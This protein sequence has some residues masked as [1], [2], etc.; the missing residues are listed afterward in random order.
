M[1]INGD[2]FIKRMDSFVKATDEHVKTTS[3]LLKRMEKFLELEDQ[4]AEEA[5][6]LKEKRAYVKAKDPLED[7]SSGIG[8]SNILLQDILNEMKKKRGSGFGDTGGLNLKKLG[9][10]AAA[11][12]A[13]LGSESLMNKIIQEA[14]KPLTKRI[15]EYGIKAVERQALKTGSE[16]VVKKGSEIVTEDLIKKG[17]E[18]IVQEGTETAAKKGSEELANKVAKTG[19]KKVLKTAAKSAAKIAKFI[20]GIGFVVATPFAIDRLMKGDYAGAALEMGSAIPGPIG[21]GIAGASAARDIWFKSDEQKQAEEG[22]GWFDPLYDK[23]KNKAIKSFKNEFI[24]EPKNSSIY[25]RVKKYDNIIESEAKQNSLSPNMIRALIAQES[26]GKSDSINTKSNAQG[27]MQLIPKTA[28]DYGVNNPLD[29]SQN[30]HGGSKLYSDLLR[31]YGNDVPKALAAYNYG[32]GNLD[33]LLK[34]HKTDWYDY[35]PDETKKYIPGVLGYYQDFSKGTTLRQGTGM[36]DVSFDNKNLPD[37]SFSN[38][39]N[40]LKDIFTGKGHGIAILDSSIDKLADRIGQKMSKYQPNTPTV[41]NVDSR[42]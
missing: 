13:A 38:V 26:G 33:K 16:S 39:V 17:T 7:I 6:R 42:R 8:K 27:L 12:G 4:K 36:P 1:P 31:Q 37:S 35:L 30:I 9:L 19:S 2:Q 22:K 32:S 29:P 15:S 25:D 3:E 24:D 20:P 5:K 40:D 23:F 34:K 21:W 11:I 10:G 41:F 18:E 14:L 28:K